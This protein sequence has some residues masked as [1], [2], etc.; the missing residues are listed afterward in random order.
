[1]SHVSG[2]DSVAPSSESE[3]DRPIRDL[4]LHVYACVQDVQPEVSPRP[5]SRVYEIG[6]SVYE[7]GWSDA[8][9]LW[10]F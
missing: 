1:M 7:I 10:I 4:L 6:W 9:A 3:S 8:R 5:G 2:R